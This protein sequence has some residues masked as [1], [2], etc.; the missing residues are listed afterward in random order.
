MEKHFTCSWCT[1][2]TCGDYSSTIKNRE[3]IFAQF[4]LNTKLFMFSSD[5]ANYRNKH[6]KEEIVVRLGF[7][8]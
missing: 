1:T 6:L 3:V 4:P 7:M 8:I 2:D 5:I